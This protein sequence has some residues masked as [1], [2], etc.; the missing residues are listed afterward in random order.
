MNETG[1]AF[2]EALYQRHADPWRFA[3]GAYEQGRYHRL[4][5]AVGDGPFPAAF[6]PGCSIGVFTALLA[7]RCH[8]LVATDLSPTAVAAAAHRCAGHPG[9]E[10]GLGALPEAVPQGRFDLIVFSELGYYFDPVTLGVVIDRLVARLRPD[11]ILAGTHWTGSSKDHRLPGADVHAALARHRRLSVARDETHP[12]FLLGVW[13][14][15]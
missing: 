7:P 15:R 9:V 6:E 2:F 11:A 4:L 14:R 8:R 10:V 3:S 12:G 1:A 13:R 5:D